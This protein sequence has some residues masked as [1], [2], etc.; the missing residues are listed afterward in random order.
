M[1]YWSRMLV[2]TGV[3]VALSSGGGGVWADSPSGPGP[4]A[5]F[6]DELKPAG[7]DLP[8]I[9]APRWN[10]PSIG[11]VLPGRPDRPRII[12]KKDS[13]FDEVAQTAK[14]GWW[15]TKATLHPRRF[16]PDRLFADR[17]EPTRQRSA[18]DSS[19]DGSPGLLRSIFGGDDRQPER[20]ATMEDFMN[21]RRPRR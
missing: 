3:T 11:S 5:R 13:L 2:I 8:E 18:A 12:R 17:G 20:V 14:Q 15:K 21:R 4:V 19:R 1:Q 9:D 7:W 6:A 16:Y 10:L